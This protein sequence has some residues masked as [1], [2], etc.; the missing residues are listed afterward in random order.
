MDRMGTSGSVSGTQPVP[1]IPLP[2]RSDPSGTRP[3]EPFTVATPRPLNATVGRSGWT[4]SSV[5]V[6]S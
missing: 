2:S 5:S 4:K 6:P 3:A 1:P